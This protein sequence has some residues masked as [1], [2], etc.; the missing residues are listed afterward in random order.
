M[1]IVQTISTFIH[2]LYD[3]YYIVYICTVNEQLK[4]RKL[5]ANTCRSCNHGA[6]LRAILSIKWWFHKDYVDSRGRVR[7]ETKCTLYSVLVHCH[8]SRKENPKFLR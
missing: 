4:Q 1:C 7:V 6:Q 2:T 3:V 8:F 5:I